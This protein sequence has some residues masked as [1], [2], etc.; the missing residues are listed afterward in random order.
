MSESGAISMT[1]KQASY[2]VGTV[3]WLAALLAPI[4][5]AHFGRKNLLFWGHIFMGLSLVMIGIF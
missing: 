1:P 2:M 3:N 4:P 5:L